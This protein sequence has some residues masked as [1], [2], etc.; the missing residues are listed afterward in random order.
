MSSWLAARY[1]LGWGTARVWVR[2]AH[3]LEGLPRIAQ[4]YAAGGL[5]W[6]QLQPLTTFATPGTD[7]RW[8]EQ[9]PGRR[10]AWLWREA[11]RHHR[12]RARE[13]EEAR[14]T[15]YLRLDWDQERSVLW[16]EGMLPAEEGT[17]LQ[18]ALHARAESIPSDPGAADPPGARLAD[19][20]VDVATGGPEPATV[21]VH[22]EAGVLTRQ[23]PETGPCLVPSSGCSGTGTEERAGS[24]DASGSGGCTPTTWSTGPMAGPPTWTTWCSCATPT[25]A[26]STRAGGGPAGIRRGSS[27]STIRGDGRS[28][29]THYG[30]RR[31]SE[32]GASPERSG[33][34]ADPGPLEIGVA[35]AAGESEGHVL[36][37]HP[38]LLDLRG[39]AVAEPGQDPVDQPPRR[40]GPAGDPDVLRAVQP[41]LVD[42]GLVVDQVGGRAHGSGHLDEPVRVRGVVG[43]DH[44]QHVRPSGHLLDRVLPVLGGVADVVPGRRLDPRE[45]LPQHL[46]DAVRFV[47]RE[48]GLGEVRDP[49]G[50]GDLD[51]AGLVDVPHQADVLGGLAAG[52]DDLLVPLVADQEDRRLFL[53]EPTGFQVDLGHQGARGIDHPEPTTGRV[54]VHLGCHPVGRQHDRGALGNLRL[55]FDEHRALPFEVTDHVDV[56]D[57]LLA[58]VH[59]RAVQAQGSLHDVHGTVHARAVTAGGRQQD[60]LHAHVLIVPSVAPGDRVG[61]TPRAG[62]D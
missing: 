59:R 27:G 49:C 42:L 61:W 29:R 33:L 4:A 3:A 25:T 9:A 48:R 58:D 6:D 54:L 51:R 53:G 21:V 41:G 55:L 44:E 46:D 16:L 10:P 23:E 2:V 30:R 37:D 7:P 28:G 5:S 17:A 13:A 52:P 1:G 8:A 56:V 38:D 15:R 43:P 24:P 40:R 60:A 39:P 18:A 20:L 50:V 11:R 12:V 45:P 31:R 34:G 35:D 32:L 19:A 57:D 47:D 22:A 62:T 26:S 36:L 14:R